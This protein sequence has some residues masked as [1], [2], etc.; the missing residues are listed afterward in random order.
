MSNL[1]LAHVLSQPETFPEKAPLT[2]GDGRNW[3]GW[4]QDIARVVARLGSDHFTACALYTHSAY[5][6][7]VG[8]V[9]SLLAGRSLLLLP[10]CQPGVLRALERQTLLL[11]DHNCED[12]GNTL[13][14]LNMA[15]LKESYAIWR[16]EWVTKLLPNASV[17]LFTSGSTGNPLRIN[18]TLGNFEAE[19]QCLEHFWGQRIGSSSIFAT[20]SHQHIYGLLFRVLWPIISG[21]P[22]HEETI[23]YP[24]Q[25]NSIDAEQSVLVSSPAFLKRVVN[26]STLRLPAMVFSSGGPLSADVNTLLREKTGCQLIEVFG[27]TETGGVASRELA[28][29][30]A[31]TLLPD[32]QGKSC[33][34]LLYIE[35]P[36][37]VAGGQLMGDR[38]RWLSARRF[39]LL[40]RADRIAKLEEKRISLQQIEE[41]LL[42][43]S[44]V[45]DCHALIL[46]GARDWLCVVLVL[47]EVG[48]S[49]LHNEGDRAFKQQVRLWLSDILEPVVL[50]RRIRFV[51]GLPLTTQ[52]KIDRARLEA[53]FHE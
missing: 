18:K 30:H 8:F 41:R 2:T 4:S 15:D 25:L 24:E 46:A 6:C 10:N 16:S 39:E 11:L 35:S 42:E 51:P 13:I 3:E 38:C 27:S 50:P 5:W 26:E 32:V 1:T 17:S 36:H 12:P 48:Q 20:V 34:G 47:S 53:L 44:E 37:C 45:D 31:W 43:Q 23:A 7:S 33:G 29:D 22:L 21:R 49:Q 9:A 14:C 28:V 19:I 52:G 40:G